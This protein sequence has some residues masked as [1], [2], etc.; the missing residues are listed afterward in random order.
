[1]GIVVE[2]CPDLCLREYGLTNRDAPEC[3]PR[4]LNIGGQHHFLK[5]GQRNYWLLGEIPLR[6]T[7][8][9]GVLSRSLASVRILE[10]A[11]FLIAGSVWTKGTY[12]IIEVYNPED[13]RIYFDGLEKIE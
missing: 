7:K 5:L 10:A 2:Y 3:L 11:H 13:G 12:K 8:G 1:M 4:E 6:E 9:N